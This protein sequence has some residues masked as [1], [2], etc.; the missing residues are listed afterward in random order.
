MTKILAFIFTAFLATN[1]LQAKVWEDTQSWSMQYEEEYQEWIKSSAVYKTMFIDPKSPYYG[2]NAD[3]ADAAYALRAIFA[4]EHSLP[5]AV[6]N[7]SGS[8]GKNLTINNSYTKWDNY[9]P[10]N[11]RLV[12]MINTI[13]LS[14]G[15][16]NLTHFDTYPIK[17]ESINPGSVFTYKISGAFG[18]F[19]R[20]VYNIKDINPVG[21]FNT[22]YSTQA[23]KAS[24][25]A[26]THRASKDFVNLPH[27]PWGFRRFRWPEYID[28]G[29]SSMDPALAASNEQFELAQKLGAKEFFKHVKNLI[30]TEDQSPEQQIG[31]TLNSICE[32]ANARIKYVSQAIDYL[33]ATNNKCMDYTDFDTYSTPARD[34]QLSEA[35]LKLKDLQDEFSDLNFE[36]LDIA[37]AILGKNNTITDTQLYAQ[38]TIAYSSTTKI[39]LKEL[40]RRMSKGLL[41]SHPNDTL[42]ARWGAQASKTKCKRWY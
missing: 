2:I 28:V 21:T 40:W 36:K 18:K 33:R 39:H 5:F 14:V 34:K 16:E 27:S 20:H 30:K 19:I 42:E 32:E 12:A 41:S 22:I 6:K 31:A 10:N 13:G 7:P 24:G 1:S 38:C 25:E 3:C 37:K 35:F 11:K 9:G 29:I 26:M 23:I 4:Y 8:R 15:S 17:L